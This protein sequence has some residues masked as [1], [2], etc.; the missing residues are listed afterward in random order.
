MSSEVG[1][2]GNPDTRTRILVATWELLRDRGASLRVGEVAERAG[3]SRQAIY[4][5]F[6][7]RTGLLVALVNYIDETL[8][9][10]ESLARV[11]AA[12]SGTD[13]LERAMRLNTEFWAKVEP[14]AR[15][16]EAA[17]YDDVALGAAWQ[18]RME[19]RQ[20]T[21]G[22]MIERLAEM[23]ELAD[24]WQVESATAVLYAI[25]HFDTWRELTRRLGWTDDQYVA[26][27]SQVLR[28][29]LLARSS[30]SSGLD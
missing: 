15:V 22:R 26:T 20:L 29:S 7:D 16:L 17:Q 3:V 27:M 4:L 6:A 14:V 8:E 23:G 21:F 2:Y 1:L 13:L 28:R 19:L 12:T 10:G 25:A 24:E 9:L 30:G 18:D 11:Q 5:H